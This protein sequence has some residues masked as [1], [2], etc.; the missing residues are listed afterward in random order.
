[1]LHNKVIRNPFIVNRNTA[2]A[3]PACSL[4]LF[5]IVTDSIFQCK[6]GGKIS[7]A[8]TVSPLRWSEQRHTCQ[9]T[10]F[11]LDI[12]QSK[13]VS[14]TNLEKCDTAS[15]LRSSSL[16]LSFSS[17]PQP[18]LSAA[19]KFTSARKLLKL[20]I[21][22]PGRGRYGGAMGGTSQLSDNP[23]EPIGKGHVLLL[24][25]AGANAG[26]LVSAFNNNSV[27][28]NKEHLLRPATSHTKLPPGHLTETLSASTYNNLFSPR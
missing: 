18:R 5:D 6:C 23:S 26:V 28:S 22:F 3:A 8:R 24:P 13:Q 20:Y 9:N 27:N 16:P 1:M 17:R 12:L 4:L 11:T 21:N 25:G 7:K 2:T 14:D 19:A 15:C 10:K